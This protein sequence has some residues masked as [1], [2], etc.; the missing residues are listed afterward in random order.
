M[1]VYA[2][3]GQLFYYI[4]TKLNIISELN[5]VTPHCKKSFFSWNFQTVK[6]RES[7]SFPFTFGPLPRPSFVQ[8]IHFEGRAN[9]VLHLETLERWKKNKERDRLKRR[10]ILY[11]SSKPD[12]K[13]AETDRSDAGSHHGKDLLNDEPER[14]I[15]TDKNNIIAS[16][17]KV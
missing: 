1:C 5:L 15:W 7:L 2:S 12:L 14:R 8:N 13:T 6:E 16:Q 9:K 17:K 11:Q 3:E 10:E 4:S